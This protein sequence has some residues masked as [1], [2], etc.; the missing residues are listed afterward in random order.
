MERRDD[1]LDV[2]VVRFP[3]AG[4]R[5]LALGDTADLEQGDRIV[6]MGSPKGLD[7]TFHEGIVSHPIRS[8]FGIGYLQI[9]GNVNPGNSGGPLLNG[10][11]EVVGIVSAKINDADGMGLA[12]PVN[13]LFEGATSMLPAGDRAP[14]EAWKKALAGVE[15]EN[16]VEL[17]R[18]RK[19]ISKPALVGFSLA[20]SQGTLAWVVRLAKALPRDE[21]LT[22]TFRREGRVL[23]RVSRRVSWQP[24][25]DLDRVESEAPLVTWIKRNK[26][27]GRIYAAQAL[28]DLSY[29]PLGGSPSQVETTVDGEEST[30]PLG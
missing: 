5:P 2:A 4:A 22:F 21:T 11:G 18:F 27:S 13:Y 19:E 14:S 17:A 30:R 9:D 24:Y 8:F 10:E 23:C 6:F 26:L 25:G 7:F 28:L 15:Q 16:Q 12:L 3:Q 20:G 1:L 29:C